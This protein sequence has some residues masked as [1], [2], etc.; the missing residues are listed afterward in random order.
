MPRVACSD[1]R[2]AGPVLVEQ[3]HER[4]FGVVFGQVF[5]VDLLDFPQM[6]GRG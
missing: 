3:A 4:A 2:R 1:E 5:D 6:A